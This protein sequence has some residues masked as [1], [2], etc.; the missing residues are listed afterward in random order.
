MTPSLQFAESTKYIAR[1]FSIIPTEA[2]FEVFVAYGAD[3]D[4]IG[5]FS[6]AEL[7]AFLERDF[8]RQRSQRTT[9]AAQEK[10]RRSYASAP[11]PDL[12]ID[13]SL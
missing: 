6:S 12:D 13:F 7:V 4:H 11:L 10:L 3:R 8:S 1:P 2:G 5:T 9:A